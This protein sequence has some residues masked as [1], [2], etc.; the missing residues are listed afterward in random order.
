[1]EKILLVQTKNVGLAI[2]LTIFFGPI[3]LFYASVSG[4]LFL[5]FGI[6]IIFI[7]LLSV[8][9]INVNIAILFSSIAILIFFL[10]FEWLISII[11]SVIAVNKYN[12]DLIRKSEKRR[13]QIEN[14]QN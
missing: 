11:W 9:L 10:A 13:R 7:I 14:I 8:G 6:P 1:M 12:K 3:G 4:A 2:I 5:I